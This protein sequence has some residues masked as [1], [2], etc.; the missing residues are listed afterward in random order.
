VIELA[1]ANGRVVE[2]DL[3]VVRLIANLLNGSEWSADTADQ[4]A[5]LLRTAGYTIADLSS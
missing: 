3:T 1:K 4:I 5:D 2:T